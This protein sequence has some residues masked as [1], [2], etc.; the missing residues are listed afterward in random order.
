VELK[1]REELTDKA[2]GVGQFGLKRNLRWGGFGAARGVGTEK[3]S[4]RGNRT[5]HLASYV[6]ID[7]TMKE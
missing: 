4:D 3:K 5:L 1:G 2:D 7:Q 6:G